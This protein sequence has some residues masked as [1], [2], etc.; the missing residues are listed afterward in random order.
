VDRTLNI[1]WEDPTALAGRAR[2]SSGVDF[3][4]AIVAGELP[5]APIQELLGFSL[6]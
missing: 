5:K 4:R 3:L 2:E 1:S 6:D